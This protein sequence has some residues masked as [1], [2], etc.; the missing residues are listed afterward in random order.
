MKL[1]HIF[2]F[3]SLLLSGCSVYDVAIDPAI[4]TEKAGEKPDNEQAIKLVKRYIKNYSTTVSSVKGLMIY[5]PVPGKVQ[6]NVTYPVAWVICYEA[7]YFDVYQYTGM[8]LKAIGVINGRIA[9][10]DSAKSYSLA[11]N[12]CKYTDNIIYEEE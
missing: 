4:A 7:N 1:L 5:E 9:E 10:D 12:F 2:I 8:V 11:D 3:I 6:R